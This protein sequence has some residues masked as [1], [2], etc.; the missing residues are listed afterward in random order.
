MYW[1]TGT[2]C[3]I[4]ATT[5]KCN[6]VI[7]NLSSSFAEQSSKNQSAITET[8][9][10]GH[11][12]TSKKV[13]C[14]LFNS[15]VN[16]TENSVGASRG[17]KTRFCANTSLS[18][19]VSQVTSPVSVNCSILSPKDG[20]SKTRSR[21]RSK[22]SDKAAGNPS[23]S[24]STRKRAASSTDKNNG[25]FGNACGLLTFKFFG[26]CSWKLHFFLLHRDQ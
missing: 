25:K 26:T 20:F 10:K 19:L 24:S 22:S 4:S 15:I 8:I 12:K 17:L 18:D 13:K 7:K 23:T 5:S 6:P 11:G 3:A 16:L 9:S 21:Q 1:L 2:I 14:D